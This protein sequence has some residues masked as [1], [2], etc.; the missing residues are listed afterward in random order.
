MVLPPAH[1]R[2]AAWFKWLECSQGEFASRIGCDQSTLSKIL[3]GTRGAGLRVAAMIE[4]ASADWPD[5]PIRAAEWAT[6]A[7]KSA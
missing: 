2:L 3:A 4:E 5:G 6:P 7:A 1:A